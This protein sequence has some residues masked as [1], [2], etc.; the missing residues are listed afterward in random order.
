[1]ADSPPIRVLIADDHQM[2]RRGLSVYLTPEAGIEVIGEAEDGEVAVEQCLALLPDVI[3]MDMIMPKM[4]GLEAIRII[5]QQ[6]PQ[7]HILALTSFLEDE[8]VHSA[9]QAGAIGYIL[10]DVSPEALI[11]AIKRAAQGEPTLSPDATK[12]L[13]KVATK[14]SIHDYNLTP[15]EVEVLRLLTEGLNNNEIADRLIISRATV[16]FH[17]STILS[18]LGVSSRTEAALLAKEHHLVD[19]RHF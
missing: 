2:V 16:K 15:R 5:K 7:Q 10:K 8:M 18:K 1:M 9:L 19:E 11:E 4:T 12:A 3:L 17:I 14:P 6:R 13:I